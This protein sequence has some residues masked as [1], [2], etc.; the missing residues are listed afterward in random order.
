MNNLGHSRQSTFTENNNCKIY[1]LIL[2]LINKIP[3][4]QLEKSSDR[5]MLFFF[6]SRYWFSNKIAKH[7]KAT[8]RMWLLWIRGQQLKIAILLLQHEIEVLYNTPRDV[9]DYRLLTSPKIS[10]HAGVNWK[11]MFVSASVFIVNPCPSD[12]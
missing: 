6:L 4:S 1:I 5:E 2:C 3:I 12:A 11:A 10:V 9:K 8:T 7:W